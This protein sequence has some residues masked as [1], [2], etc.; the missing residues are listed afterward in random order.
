MKEMFNP[1]NWKD[2]EKIE[3][4]LQAIMAKSPNWPADYEQFVRK[5]APQVDYHVMEGVGHFLMMEKPKE[6]NE[7]MMSFLKKQGL[8]KP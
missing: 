5:I 2:D 7:L 4:P 1:V 6:F 8:V 3:A